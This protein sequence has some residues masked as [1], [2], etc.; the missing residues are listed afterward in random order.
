MLCSDPKQLEYPYT[1][2][3]LGERPDDFVSS[4]G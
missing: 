3:I 2:M 4:G 1:F